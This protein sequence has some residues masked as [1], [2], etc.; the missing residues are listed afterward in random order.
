MSEKLTT[1]VLVTGAKGFLGK[2]LCVMLRRREG[3]ELYEY[4]L[5]V[6]PAIL[7]RALQSASVI[8]H[9]AGVNR[10]VDQSEFQKHNAGFT[11]ELCARLLALHRAPK[12]VFASSVQ[13]ELDNPY[14]ASK[15]EAEAILERFAVAS[16]AECVVY[17]LKNLFGKWCRPN[18]NSVTAT[19]CHNIARDLPIE[20]SD[21]SR[22]IDLTYVDDVVAAFLSDLAPGPS[23]FRQ[24]A[25]LRSYRVTLGALANQIREFRAMR[26][27]LFLPS[28][29][30]P[31]TRPLYATYLTY[32]E[33]TEFAYDL[34]VKVDDRGR[35]AEFIKS[36][37]SGQLF[38]SRTRP[39]VTRGN[40][41]HNT[42][43]EKFLVVHGEAIIRFRHIRSSNVIEYRVCGEDYRVLDIPPGYTHS[44]ENVGQDELV[45][46][47]WAAESFDPDHPDTFFEEVQVKAER[48]NQ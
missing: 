16:G 13:A 29:A 46:L 25:P 9:L 19:F 38:I 21:P 7:E 1:T 42:K 48:S 20:I 34:D 43:T 12:V 3:L 47:F 37:T 45:T 39:G 40:H 27:T 24:S 6:S 4:D 36:A 23:G 33:D 31:F 8:F 32:L 26:T 35:L 2:N 22:E 11:E 10:P 5:G 17:R 41:Y 28:F 14:G 15:R 30:D 44:I 18:Y